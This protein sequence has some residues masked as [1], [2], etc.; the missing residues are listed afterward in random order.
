MIELMRTSAHAFVTSFWFNFQWHSSSLTMQSN[1][2]CCKLWIIKLTN[3]SI[4][5]IRLQFQELHRKFVET[6]FVCYFVFSRW[7]WPRVIERK[8]KICKTHNMATIIE[9]GADCHI[10]FTWAAKS[11]T[12]NKPKKVL[13]N[14]SNKI[15]KNQPT[16]MG[17]NKKCNRW[18]CRCTI[19]AMDLFILLRMYLK[20]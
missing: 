16:E 20:S 13:K 12:I 17:Q 15:K 5:G 14:W 11:K 2:N 6:I 4:G 10:R 19:N 18:Q 9:S 3:Y 7:N 8:N 1:M